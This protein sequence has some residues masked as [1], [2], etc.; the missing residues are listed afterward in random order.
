M[1]TAT[2]LGKSSIL[3]TIVA[4]TQPM[5]YCPSAPILNR[6]VLIA[7]ATPSPVKIMGVERMITLDM[8][9]GLP[10]MLWTSVEI[11]SAGGNPASSRITLATPKPRIM[12]MIVRTKG[13]LKNFF[14]VDSI[15]PPFPYC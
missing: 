7:N 10:T 11:D 9:L 8:S 5:I 3:P 2:G 12:A 13:W 4:T 15:T 1:I 14:L 6:P